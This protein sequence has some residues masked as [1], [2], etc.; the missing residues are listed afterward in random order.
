MSEKFRPLLILIA[1]FVFAFSIAFLQGDNPTNE[2]DIEKAPESD[3]LDRINPD[4]IKTIV[5]PY[6]TYS[7]DDLEK[8]LKKLD[9][10][11]QGLLEVK[12]IGESVTGKELY[13]V[14]LG[15]EEDNILIEGSH[16]G[17]EWLS[18]NLI[19]TK[20]D[21]YAYAYVTG[22][23]IGEYNVREILD[24]VGIWFVPMVNPDGVT[25]NQK[26]KEGI[27][28]EYCEQVKEHNVRWAKDDFYLWKANINGVDL[29]R[30][31]PADWEE[32]DCIG[33]R[34][35]MNYKGEEPLS[36]PESQAMYDFTKQ[37]EPLTAAS[38]HTRGQVIFWYYHNKHLE[39]DRAIGEQLSEMTG[40]QLYPPRS[41]YKG[42]NFN[43]WFIQEF[44]RP[45]YI[46]ELVP[47]T[48]REDTQ[49][50]DYMEVEWKNNKEVGLFLSKIANEKLK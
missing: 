15:N 22:E 34:Y 45:A 29:N 30:Q 13:A 10:Q 40:Y 16:H 48:G 3:P 12:N 9:K 47:F 36:E 33:T 27:P 21:R 25:L 19:M 14:R 41:D 8:D 32:S 24:E 26:G 38:Y 50:L 23:K 44:D 37:I 31:Y 35:A 4:R 43:D 28:E 49:D 42:A 39:R 6:Q 20:I 11:Y 2:K 17:R 18:T 46:F 7:F 5:D 1:I